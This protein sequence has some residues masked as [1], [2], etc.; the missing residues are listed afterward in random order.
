MALIVLYLALWITVE[1]AWTIPP[2]I[3]EEW[4]ALQKGS[5]LKHAANN[6]NSLHRRGVTLKYKYVQS[7]GVVSST[8]TS[9]P[10]IEVA[11]TL[12]VSDYAHQVAATTVARVTKHMP[13]SIFQTLTT[14]AKVG[15][16]TKRETLTIYPEYASL[17]TP[18][19]CESSCSGHCASS[20]TFDGRKYSTL[21]GTGGMRTV[22]VDD[23]VLCNSNDP[24]NHQ[25]NILV[26]EFSHTIH[27]YGL[28]SALKSRITSAYAHAKAY[29]T[30]Q[31]R[32]YSMANELEYFAEAS[33]SFFAAEKLSYSTGGM[34]TCGLALCRTEAEERQHIRERDPELYAILS[35]VFTNNRPSLPG[36]LGV[37][38]N[39]QA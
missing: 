6:K 12:Y 38:T 17:A 31:D 35:E 16:F 34:N 9:H 32:A 15:V 7:N 1:V 10:A 2:P 29:S 20:C 28:S 8:Y 21:A 37:C 39:I 18:P 5:S 14:H 26:H 23:N 4:I 11:A 19:G 30:W 3:P 27:T 22:V 33:Q 36:N 24:Y 25:S 13:P